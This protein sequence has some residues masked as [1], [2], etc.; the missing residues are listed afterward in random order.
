MKRSNLPRFL[1]K[2]LFRVFI[3]GVAASIIASGCV[4]PTIQYQVTPTATLRVMNF[5]PNC[6]S[7]MDVF[8]APAPG[9][10]PKKAAKAYNLQYGAASVYTTSI[11]V[12]AIGTPYLVDICPTRDTTK[13]DKEVPITLMPSGKYSIV[14]THDTVVTSNFLYTILNDDIQQS[15][16]DPT[17]QT[18]VRF[19][20]LQANAGS[21]SVRVNDPAAGDAITPAGGTPFNNCT[22]YL[23]L[24]T[25]L[26]T[27]F[28]F[29][30]TN[31][32]NQIIA[33]LTYQTFVAGSY[34]TLV[35]AGDLCNT[36]LGNPADTVNDAVDTL[37][38][39]VLD[40]NGN[41]ADQTN[42][43]PTTY[44]YNI[45]NALTPRPGVKL[46][47]V[48]Y[49]VNGADFP[50]YNG[51]SVPAIPVDGE[52]GSGSSPSSVNSGVLNV[53][54][55]SAAIPPGVGPVPVVA[56]GLNG[57]VNTGQL[58][59]ASMTEKSPFDTAIA[60]N[61]T[62]SF[63][64]YD[65]IG[66]KLT[67]S[68]GSKV[69]AFS[70]PDSSDPNSV[71]LVFVPGVMGKST[72]TASLFSY[73]V[74]GGPVIPWKW[75]SSATKGAQTGNI[76][77]TAKPVVKAAVTPGASGIPITITASLYGTNGTTGAIPLPTKTFNAFAGGIYEIVSVGD[78]KSDNTS[79]LN[80][81]VI[82]VNA[83][84]GQ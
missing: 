62:V 65:T 45:I 29:F 76:G 2:D 58:F 25:A 60:P 74:N 21:L 32:A 40:D 72:T 75:N 33:K 83:P 46:T 50:E 82:C 31:S 44:R 39:R 70:V 77:H 7:P 1:A 84:P 30:V 78:A 51:F 15:G 48:G 66:A 23:A 56:A 28:A 18:Y 49:T 71:T 4:S 73:S 26:D 55:Q 3:A 24:K 64:F 61:H 79:T 57:S 41:G 16:S 52:G 47:S 59:T 9:P 14:I 38:L 27:S 54:Y 37:R 34:Y 63:L 43:V 10:V 80:V 20:N 68:E 42:P 67:G 19:M 69:L 17:K 6:T 5:A 12:A 81:L 35:Y 13:L 8:W 53:T 22:P 11:P 36:P